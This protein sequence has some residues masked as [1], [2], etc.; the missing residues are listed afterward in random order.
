MEA[1]YRIRPAGRIIFTIGEDLI[2][3][4]YAALVELV[5]N[6]YDADSPDVIITFSGKK[7]DNYFEISV[8]DSGHGMSREDVLSKWLVPAT[9]Y[10]SKKR[11]SPGG[12]IMQGS[13]GIGR[14]A[15]SILGD[16]LFLETVT[17]E[18]E[19]TELYLDWNKFRT[20]EFIDQV[21]VLVESGKT[22]QSR[23]TALTIHFAAERKN[24]WNKD[25][26]NKLRYELKKL[27]PPLAE[28]IYNDPFKIFLCFDGIFLEQE[29]MEREEITPYPILDLFDYRISG[30]IEKDGSGALEYECQKAHGKEKNKICVGYGDTGCG[31]LII[32]IR[33]YDRDPGSVNELIQ[34]GL[35]NESTQKYV[36]NIE[37]RRLLN[38]VNGIGVYRN[39]FRIRPL[40]DADFDW[41][42]LNEQ[43]IQK[44]AMQIGSN[45]VVGY[46][47]IE[48]EDIS[49]L[50][51]K[52]ARDG[53]KNNNAYRGLK[54]ITGR[55]IM[56]LQGRRY[57]FRRKIGLIEKR[58]KI[59]DELKKL[60]NYDNLKKDIT[61]RLRK[62]SLSEDVIGEIVNIISDEQANKNDAVDEIRRMIAIYQ[63]QATLGKIINVILHE[64]R[65]PLNYF[66]N[67]I[68]NLEYYSGKFISDH[69]ET[70][71]NKILHCTSG[72]AENADIF[73]AFF[74]KLDPL[75][76]KQIASMVDF[77]II[78]VISN[79]VS[80]FEKELNE[81]EIKISI[82]CTDKIYF[83]GWKQDFYTIFTNLLDNSIYWIKAQNSE[84]KEIRID[85]SKEN[86]ELQIDYIDS[87]PGIDLKFLESDV[88]FEPEFSTKPGGTGLGLAIAGE[89]ASR[90]QLTLIALQ[91][92][93]GAYFRLS[94]Q[95]E[96]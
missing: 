23:G 42:K 77:S 88:I 2:Q 93:D 38:D 9:D 55:A 16:D 59:Y 40:G 29:N 64:C 20:N 80:V 32:D 86:N 1:S 48:S 66:K 17:E 60:Y 44:P 92:D 26:L 83:H 71:L 82:N 54:Y 3:D 75:S 36:S 49:H 89:A 15:A 7:E 5:K 21:E 45:Q 24:E 90:N 6:A 11:K 28:N 67:Q 8:K 25:A 91:N 12:R 43:R 27:V 51:E 72:I 31:K 62:A 33:V 19:E 74:G 4:G 53:L 22:D 39:G 78:G 46:V 84:T 65:R 76:A 70:N 47:H 61:V 50:V 35:K 10:K 63:G 73:V 95:K 52:S 57:I 41:L 96:M 13:K 58:G 37:A 68:P 87:G 34:R 81:N 94:T 30:V 79:V 14:Y 56:E 18:G 69:S 85:V